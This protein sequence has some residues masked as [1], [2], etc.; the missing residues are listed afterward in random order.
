MKSKFTLV[1]ISQLVH[2]CLH[3][4]L[5]VASHLEENVRLFE[6]FFRAGEA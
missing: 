6:N 4:E 5:E 1:A 2:S 3:D